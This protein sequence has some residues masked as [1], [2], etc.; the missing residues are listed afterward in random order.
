MK[1]LV[2][3]WVNYIVN[4]YISDG[5]ATLTN[6]IA[7]FLHSSFFVFISENKKMGIAAAI[8]R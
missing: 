6:V 2:E 7:R 3:L 5:N 1:T 4:I 8:S